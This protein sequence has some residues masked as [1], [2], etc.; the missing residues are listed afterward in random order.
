MHF[1]MKYQKSI[2]KLNLSEN[3]KKLANIFKKYGNY[4][5]AS[6]SIFHGTSVALPIIVSI[7][8][9]LGI[10]TSL[11][12][13]DAQDALIITAILSFVTFNWHFEMGST[14]VKSASIFL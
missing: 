5:A 2:G 3:D 9:A 12:V 8:A 14:E 7:V 10:S 1:L 4:L 11:L 13:H 6:E